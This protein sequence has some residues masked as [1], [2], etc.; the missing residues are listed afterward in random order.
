[1]SKM[2]LPGFEP[3]LEAVS[4]LLVK[5]LLAKGWLGSPCHNRW[6]TA[7][8]FVSLILP[9]PIERSEMDTPSRGVTRA[10]LDHSRMVCLLIIFNRYIVYGL[11]RIK[12]QCANGHID[13]NLRNVPAVTCYSPKAVK[14]GFLQ[15]SRLNILWLKQFI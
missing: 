7:A 1:M 2:R 5:L 4:R 11:L 3:G 13:S 10:A 8:W 14:H 9:S 6:T 12:S 15:D